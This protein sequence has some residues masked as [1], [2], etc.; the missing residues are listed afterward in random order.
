MANKKR[1]VARMFGRRH[2]HPMRIAA[3]FRV[4]GIGLVA[5]VLFLSPADTVFGVSDLVYAE[6]HMPR[7]HPLTWIGLALAFWATIL[8]RPLR[9]SR[10]RER[11]LWIAVGL[12]A[13]S[14]PV[15]APLFQNL[16]PA[17]GLGMMGVNTATALACLALGQLLRQSLPRLGM[18]FAVLPIFFAAVSLNG[19]LIGKDAFYGEMALPTA[20]GLF[21][22]GIANL[23]R[24]SRRVPVR[25][26]LQDTPA[27]HLI[28]MHILGW[29]FLAA[30][31]PVGLRMVDMT[32]G[33]SFAALYTVQMCVVLIGILYFGARFSDMLDRS[34]RV[35]R[36]MTRDI[37]TD[38]LTGAATRRT[39][40]DGFDRM[41]WRGDTG[42][43]V[44]DIDHFKAVN[45]THGHA[46]GDHVLKLV[47]KALRQDLRLSD[48]LVRWGGEELMILLPISSEAALERRADDLRAIVERVSSEAA[49]IPKV[50]ASFGAVLVRR[51]IDADFAAAFSNADSAL[52][53]AKAQG[54][55]RVVMGQLS[56]RPGPG[57]QRVAKPQ[58]A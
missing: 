24:Y 46:V 40:I 10:P 22:L 23:T 12:L 3:L 43:I 21:G 25:H 51:S 15:A 7:T 56:T 5:L 14:K 44:A 36:N 37:E 32:K 18:V 4:F 9:L 28:R 1:K 53:E 33:A 17:I 20:L 19:L 11:T 57:M 35:Q 6:G 8:Q 58:A 49:G 30:I 13:A 41:I 55:N 48:L 52:Y 54:R 29:A 47:T 34:R 27:S 38:A 50:T 31:M 2:R 26:L 42:L 45:D 39:A 16:F